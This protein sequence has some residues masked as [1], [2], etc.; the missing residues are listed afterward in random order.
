M[1]DNAVSDFFRRELDKYLDLW[2]KG[3]KKIANREIAK[4]MLEFDNWDL[5]QQKAILFELCDEICDKE[6]SK[7]RCMLQKFPYEL[8]K[9]MSKILYQVSD[10]Y[11]MP[12]LRWCYELCGHDREVLRKAYEHPLCDEKTANYYFNIYLDDLWFGSHHFPE[13][14]LMTEEAY[15]AAIGYC[16]EIVAQHAIKKE[17][18]K[19]YAYY[20]RLYEAWWAYEKSG[21]KYN[22]QEFCQD[23]ELKFE[24]VVAYYYKK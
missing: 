23:Q 13:Y 20:K 8:S 2:D 16:E 6:N 24:P 19:E 18:K 10:E 3:L 11:G 9:R 12:Y 1:L 21:H 4:L 22:F 17:L 7:Y 14:S 5:R 15:H